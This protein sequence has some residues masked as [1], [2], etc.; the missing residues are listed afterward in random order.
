MVKLRLTR[1]GRHK[2]AFFRLVATDS[3]NNVNGGYIELLGSYD[4]LSGEIKLQKENIINWL[5][6]G[7][8]P[9]ETVKNIL[10]SNGVWKEFVSSKKTHKPKSKG[11][12]KV[13]KSSDKNSNKS[14][15]EKTTKK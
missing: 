5:N 11:L 12:N 1:I 13:K 3:R 15:K 4:P 8:Q 9:S 2:R 6:K 10:K 7:A 14:K